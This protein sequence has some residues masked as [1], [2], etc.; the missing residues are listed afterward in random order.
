M[1]LKKNSSIQ[2]FVILLPVV[3]LFCQGYT[4]RWNSE[5]AFITFRVVKNIL[6]GYGPVYNIDERVE[7]YT[8]PL[9]VAILTL[10]TFITGSIEY[11]AF[12]LGLVFSCLG[13]IF[14]ELGAIKLMKNIKRKEGILVPFGALVISFLPPFWD[15]ATSGLETGL[16]FLWLGFSFFLM[17]KFLFNLKIVNLLFGWL[18]IGP[19]IRPDLGLIW[20]GPLGVS[21][22]V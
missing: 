16:S 11:S 17:V 1:G 8:H 12:W 6:N 5:D 14:S 3:F 19:L 13:L 2:F 4:H 22:I 9:W 20:M 18:S 7:A 15:F 10:T 21:T